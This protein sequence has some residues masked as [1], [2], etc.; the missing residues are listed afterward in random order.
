MKE[1]SQNLFTPL[2]IILIGASLFIPSNKENWSNF[3]GYSNYDTAYNTSILS[4]NSIDLSQPNT[5]GCPSCTPCICPACPTILDT[6]TSNRDYR[7]LSD[8][9]YPPEQRSDSGSYTMNPN[10]QNGYFRYPTRG[11]PPPY[12]LK[13]YL[14]DTTN[15]SNIL[16][17]FGR[18]KYPGSTEFQYYVSK[19]DVN[20]NEIKIDIDNKRELFNNDIVVIKK[21][22]FTGEYKFV[23]LKMEDLV[24]QP[25]Y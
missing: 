1:L 20:N 10:A 11:Y 17:L 19:K 2:L 21:A 13:G 16:S 14:V 24:Q 5:P 18:P 6:N 3:L 22:I 8:P 7:V 25:L 4:P 12:Q 9:L 23:E 15:P